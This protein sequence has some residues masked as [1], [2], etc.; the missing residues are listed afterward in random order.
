MS[1]FPF[2]FPIQLYTYWACRDLEDFYA[3]ELKS[4]L[5][6][7]SL[8]RQLLLV[9][10]VFI[11]QVLSSRRGIHNKRFDF[12]Q[13]TTDIIPSYT[14]SHDHKNHN[15]NSILSMIHPEFTRFDFLVEALVVVARN[16][17]QHSE[18]SVAQQFLGDA[19]VLCDIRMDEEEV[20]DCFHG[21][22]Q[23]GISNKR[24][25][26]MKYQHPNAVNVNEKLKLLM[27]EMA[28]KCCIANNEISQCIYYGKV[29]LS[30]L[31]S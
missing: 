28:L 25:S 27:I 31:I 10:P 7:S 17:L 8:T 22:G 15:N 11:Q 26:I 1:P 5:P 2:L 20:V 19:L 3:N 13:P 18:I 23:R 9:D 16:L 21:V 24:R 30:L 14:R 6:P 29:R 12:Q 4:L